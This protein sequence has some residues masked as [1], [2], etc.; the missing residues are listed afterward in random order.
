[1]RFAV[2]VTESAASR[3]SHLEPR[4]SVAR[5]LAYVQDVGAN[6]G[7]VGDASGRVI[8]PGRIPRCPCLPSLDVDPFGVEQRQTLEYPAW[9][10]VEFLC[11]PKHRDVVSCV[12]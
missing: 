8:S 5:S 2:E 1:M 10:I 7:V 3:Q 12:P 9:L 6:V 4:N 11:P